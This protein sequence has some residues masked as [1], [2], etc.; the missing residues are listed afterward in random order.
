MIAVALLMSGDDRQGDTDQWTGEGLRREAFF[1]DSGGERLYG[2]LYAAA[3][4]AHSDGVVV[5][6]SWGFE[7]N[8]CDRTKHT[9]AIAAARAGGAGLV[10]D[11]AGFGDSSGRPGEA[12]LEGLAANA[13][14]AVAEAARRSHGER[15]TLAGLMLGAAVAALGAARADV[16]R[17][18]LVQPA[19]QPSRYFRRLERSATRAAARVPARAG[20]AY[21]YPLPRGIVEA[22]AEADATVAAALGDFAGDGA[23]VRH[24]EPQPGAIAPQRF[25]DVVVPGRWRFGARQAPSLAEAAIGQIG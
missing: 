3:S 12:T 18:L 15:W 19:L 14:D 23:V 10:F 7:A 13:R 17:L 11:Y 2:S 6:N 9:I 25:E 24:E 1:F 5:C 4:P 20:T 22:G 21:G 16:S 8:Q